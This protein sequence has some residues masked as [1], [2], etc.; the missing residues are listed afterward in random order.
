MSDDVIK[1]V[2]EALFD[3]WGTGPAP[4]SVDMSY[5]Q[6]K[7]QGFDVS[8]CAPGRPARI[9]KNGCSTIIYGDDHDCPVR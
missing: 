7:A 8:A 6:A 2:E 1:E 3:I 4:E 5:D 9:T